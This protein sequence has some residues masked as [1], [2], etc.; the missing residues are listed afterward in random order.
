VFNKKR[1]G[2]KNGWIEFETQGL[3]LNF[4]NALVV[5]IACYLNM[6]KLIVKINDFSVSNLSIGQVKSL[7]SGG[8]MASLFYKYGDNSSSTLTTQVGSLGLP[9]GMNT[10][11]KAGPVKYSMDLSLRGYDENPNI[12]TIYDAFMALDNWMI[13]QGVKNSK[14]WFKADLSRDV[15]KA[16]Y[17]PMVKVAKDQDGNPKPYPPTIK[18]NLKKQ[19]D[20]FDVKVY[21]DQKRPYEG[22]PLED[23]LV[24]GAMLTTLIQ[25]TSVWFAGSK[26]GLS[27]KAKQIRMDRVPE[28]IRGYA[29][30]EDDD[31]AARPAPSSSRTPSSNKFAALDADA[32]EDDAEV[33]EDDV[34]V[35]APKSSVVSAMLPKASTPS[36]PVAAPAPATIDD[37]AEDHEPIPVPAKKATVT[38]KK[39]AV[40]AAGKK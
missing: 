22:V 24:K 13:D 12:K 26:F 5:G 15:V 34:E 40:K 25:C 3:K 39:V 28:S 14:A 17:T 11:D 29:F 18:I 10:F 8:K 7:E 30:L 27:W 2:I 38:A 1:A 9:Y 16:F 20:Q 33:E 31:A 36:V 19:N 23:L 32:E 21:D 6:S 37:E 4:K 35:P